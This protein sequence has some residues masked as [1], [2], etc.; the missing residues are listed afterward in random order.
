[1]RPLQELWLVTVLLASSLAVQAADLAPALLWVKTAGGSGN[2]SVAAAAADARGNLY[3]V[4][5][6]TSLDFPLSAAA[7]AVP[8]GS[9]LVRI[10]LVTASATRLF[11]ASLPAITSAAAAPENSGTLYAA[12]NSQIWKSTDAG[13][14]WTKIFQFPASV[15]VFGLAV[16]PITSS[17][18]Y[19]ATSTVGI[20]KSMDGGLTWTAI[21]TGIP[22]SPNGTISVG[23]VWVESASPNVIFASSGSGLARSIDDGNTWTLIAGGDSFT[24]LAFDPFTSGTLY[25]ADGNAIS[26]STDNGQTFVQ[27]SPLPNPAALFTLA[28]DPHHAGVL[29]A[30]T[31]AGIYQSSDGEAPGT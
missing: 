10:N 17:T 13:S 2:N 6:T 7:Q 14:T 25:F 26:K 27:L 3:I 9:M 18:V 15:S 21:N 11:P 22:H 20:Y 24:I 16:N 8:G 31:S 23:R 29:Y 19:A 5:A 4:G 1:M 28:P 12:A 30:G